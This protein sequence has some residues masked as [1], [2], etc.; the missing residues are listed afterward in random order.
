[1]VIELTAGICVI[2]AALFAALWWRMRASLAAAEAQR[3]AA[4]TAVAWAAANLVTA[5]LA[6][7]LWRDRSAAAIAIA[8][9]DESFAEFVARLE[10]G[11]AAQLETALVELRANSSPF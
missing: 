11:G 3:D 5:P 4:E 2:A 8:A 9:G 1:M 7:F 10:P 6:G